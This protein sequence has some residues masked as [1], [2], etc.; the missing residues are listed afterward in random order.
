M[1][2]KTELTPKQREI[3][4]WIKSQILSTGKSPTIREI[5]NHFDYKSTA[6][7]HIKLQ[8]LIKHG[9][10]KRVEDYS[11]RGYE[12]TQEYH[13]CAMVGCASNEAM[14]EVTC[15]LNNGN[16]LTLRAHLCDNCH[17]KA[18]SPARA[19]VSIGSS[20]V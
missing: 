18:F 16:A 19:I 13:K 17:N 2:P 12:L 7:G 4:E 20:H 1:K 14:H 9:Y 11:P 10:L 3:Y 5:C 15:S 8:I 6:S